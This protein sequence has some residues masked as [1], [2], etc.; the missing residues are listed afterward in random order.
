MKQLERL[1]DEHLVKMYAVG[2]NKAFETLLFRYKD[3]VYTYIY[4][5]VHNRELAEDIFQ[6]TFIK[7]ITCIKQGRYAHTNKFLPW[8]NRI[9]YNLVIDHFR[10]EKRENVFSSDEDELFNTNSP[11]ELSIEDVMLHEQ[12]LNDVV[13][14]MEHLPQQQKQVVHMRFFEQLSFQE[15]A[16]ETNVSVNTALGRMRYALIN[17]RKLAKEYQVGYYA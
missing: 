16:D 11:L 7:A 2:D 17:M 3:K 14:L 15:I 1:T 4:L 9:A 12:N 6:E 8:V 5:I 10:K 13:Y